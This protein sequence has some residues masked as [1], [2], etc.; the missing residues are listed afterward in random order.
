MAESAAFDLVCSEVESRTSLDRLASR[1]TV[2][3]ALKL[4][5]LDSRTVTPSEIAVAV[6]R[7]L[8]GELAS[9]GI[10]DAPKICA[11]IA[12]KAR[13]LSGGSKAET[14][15]TVFGRLGG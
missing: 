11:E 13:G 14:P 7:L 5:G 8:A 6:E 9:R 2:R 4:A 12:A 15:H 1:G 3:I 10:D